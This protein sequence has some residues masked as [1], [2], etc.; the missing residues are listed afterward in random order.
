M[1]VRESLMLENRGS[2]NMVSTVNSFCSL[3]EFCLLL[4]VFLHKQHHLCDESP[5]SSEWEKHCSTCKRRINFASK[6][7][8]HLAKHG[9]LC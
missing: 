9:K 2:R 7:V 3:K 1:F 4:T 6:S 8:L 5:H